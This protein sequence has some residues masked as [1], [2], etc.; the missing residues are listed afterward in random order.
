MQ[1]L[2]PTSRGLTRYG[3]TINKQL[4][5][6]NHVPQSRTYLGACGEVWMELRGGN[7][8]AGGRFSRRGILGDTQG[9]PLFGDC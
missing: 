7:G 4:K 2:A 3:S 9:E 6:S 1:K 8:G 5:P